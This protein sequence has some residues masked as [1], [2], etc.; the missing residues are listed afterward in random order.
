MRQTEWHRLVKRYALPALHERWPEASLH[1]SW[2][3]V[4]NRDHR[5][6][7]IGW[8]VRRS[9]RVLI[10]NYAKVHLDFASGSPFSIDDL[11][12]ALGAVGERESWVEL[13]DD[14]AAQEQ[15]MGVLLNRMLDQGG[16]FFDELATDDQIVSRLS[17]VA[18]EEHPLQKGRIELLAGLA[19]LH[20]RDDEAVRWYEAVVELSERDLA[21][22]RT[23]FAELQHQWFTDCLESART[24]PQRG[25]AALV[26]RAV[27]YREEA[28]LPPPPA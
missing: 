22:R 27:E 10:S 20:N 17:A 12:L 23:D 1:K 28:K 26:G 2:I 7:A 13:G 3:V 16:S 24:D 15:A 8:A 14:P 25:R 11:N 9:K 18:A 4:E 6:S 21:L 5:C 19:M